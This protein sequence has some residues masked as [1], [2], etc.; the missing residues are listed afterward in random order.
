MPIAG[1]YPRIED[2]PNFTVNVAV[3]AGQL[4]EPDAATAKVKPAT[5]G[6]TKVLGVAV[7]NGYPAGSTPVLTFIQ[8]SERVAVE[9]N[10]EMYVTF[11]ADTLFGD[12]LIAA[13]NGQVTPSGATPDARTL[14]GQCTEPAGVLAGAV[15]RAFIK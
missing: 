10:H 3:T 11:A 13:A 1:G 9:R 8:Q 5:A 6:T 2:T 14:V 4:V 15:G 12:R 7:T